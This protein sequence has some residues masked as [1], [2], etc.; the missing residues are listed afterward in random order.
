M[1]PLKIDSPNDLTD[2][3]IEISVNEE[4]SLNTHSPNFVKED[5]IDISFKEVHFWNAELP[6]EVTEN[7]LSKIILINAEPNVLIQSNKSGDRLFI[8]H[9]DLFT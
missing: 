9:N 8:W 2:N 6:N 7:G 1:Q 4:Q 3:G 5:G